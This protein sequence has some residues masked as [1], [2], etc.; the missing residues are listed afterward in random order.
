[1]GKLHARVALVTGAGRGIGAAIAVASGRAGAL[2]RGKIINVTSQ[3][4]QT[5]MPDHAHYAAA[6]AGVIGFT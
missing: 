2:G 6:Q 1:M 4:G 5:G 3:L